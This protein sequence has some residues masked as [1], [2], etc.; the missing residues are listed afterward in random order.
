MKKTVFIPGIWK[1]RGGKSIAFNHYYYYIIFSACT[2]KN[3]VQTQASPNIAFTFPSSVQTQMFKRLHGCIHAVEE[4][5][6]DLIDLLI[7]KL[8]GKLSHDPNV[9]LW[10]K[11]LHGKSGI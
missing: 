1:A 6:N 5:L 7:K 3:T 11:A 4:N 2:E 8:P 9:N 10:G